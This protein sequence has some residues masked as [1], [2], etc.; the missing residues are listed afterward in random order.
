MRLSRR[1]AFF[2]FQKLQV[3]GLQATRS[4]RAYERQLS[5]ALLAP[6]QRSW[7]GERYCARRDDVN[8]AQPEGCIHFVNRYARISMNSFIS[9]RL[10]FG[11]IWRLQGLHNSAHPRHPVVLMSGKALLCAYSLIAST[12]AARRTPK[13]GKKG[14][15]QKGT[16]EYMAH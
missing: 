5:L 16:N 3:L 8:G 6:R 14:R 2:E 10:H 15:V 12:A 11:S 7:R 4:R 9:M 13:P 1:A